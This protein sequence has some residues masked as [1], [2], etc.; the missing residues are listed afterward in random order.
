MRRLAVG[1]I[2]DLCLQYEG[3]ASSHW[4]DH[5]AGAQ[6]I[7]FAVYDRMDERR[8][9]ARLGIF[10][11]ATGRASARPKGSCT[12]GER[13][14]VYSTAR[15]LNENGVFMTDVARRAGVWWRPMPHPPS[16]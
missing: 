12:G 1:K 6:R 8:L 4:P 14:Y 2:E 7:W 3:F 10:E 9:R 16:S 13:K 15:S 11:E 5:L